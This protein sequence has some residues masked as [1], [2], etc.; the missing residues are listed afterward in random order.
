M[1]LLA[2]KG[3]EKFLYLLFL[4]KDNYESFMS[5]EDFVALTFIRLYPYSSFK[6]R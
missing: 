5:V 4:K 2:A 1:A 6:Y 3:K